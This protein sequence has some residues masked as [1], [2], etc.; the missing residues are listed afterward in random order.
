M[1]KA[2]SSSASSGQMSS[3]RCLYSASRPGKSFILKATRSIT[4]SRKGGRRP[5]PAP[6]DQKI[7]ASEV[8][9]VDV[10]GVERGQ[11][12]LS[13]D[14]VVRIDGD[15]AQVRHLEGRADFVLDRAV[16]HAEREVH[17]QPAFIVRRP[18]L[19]RL[20]G[21]VLDELAHFAR[22]PPP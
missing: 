3:W 7:R 10:L 11:F 13:V 9:L 19:E 20:D 21:A 18:E 15:G 4:G 8:E 5:K 17:G 22:Q 1:P 2:A 6:Q 14:R 16:E 12:G